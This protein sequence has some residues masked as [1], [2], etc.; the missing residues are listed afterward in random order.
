MVRSLRTIEQV[1]NKPTRC[2][3]R[4]TSPHCRPAHKTHTTR[5]PLNNKHERRP[6]GLRRFHLLPMSGNYLCLAIFRSSVAR[7]GQPTTGIG[8][9]SWLRDFVQRLVGRRMCYL[10]LFGWWLLVVQPASRSG[11]LQFAKR[12]IG[13]G[14][15]GDVLQARAGMR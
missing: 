3:R 6:I 13:G 8:H 1:C 10:N 9:I 5:A 4:R 11:S 14:G 7:V 2:L 15:G 12:R